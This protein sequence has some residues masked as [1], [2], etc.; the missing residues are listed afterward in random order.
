MHLS[1]LQ[2]HVRCLSWYFVQYLILAESFRSQA[3]LGVNDMVFFEKFFV[4][5]FVLSLALKELTSFIAACM[6]LWF[7]F[8][9]ETALVVHQQVLAVVKQCLHSVRTFPQPRQL[10]LTDHRHASD[11]LMYSA[12][13]VRGKEEEEGSFVVTTL[14]FPSNR[15]ALCQR[16]PL[17]NL[18]FQEVA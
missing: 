11:L 15:Y 3:V 12:I 5:V 8:E 13:K 6:L 4:F 14:V 2:T 16:E 1:G 7:P 9:F 17:S 10:T 18:A